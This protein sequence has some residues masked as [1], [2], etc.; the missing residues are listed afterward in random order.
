[1]PPHLLQN[2]ENLQVTQTKFTQKPP[3]CVQGKQPY[4]NQQLHPGQF[5]QQSNV[6]VI[7]NNQFV[8]PQSQL[9]RAASTQNMHFRDYS[10]PD[11]ILSSCKIDAVCNNEEERNVKTKNKCNK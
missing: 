2:G 6:R 1:M 11:Q 5:I 9:Q 7:Q 4:I 8:P 3:Q 10:Q